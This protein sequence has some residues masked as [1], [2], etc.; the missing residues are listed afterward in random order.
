[1]DAGTF[2]ALRREVAGLPD[3]APYVE[4][5]RWLLADPDTRPIS[6]GAR[7]TPAAAGGAAPPLPPPRAPRR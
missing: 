4:W 6:P 1:V 2:D 5:G 7:A 3:D